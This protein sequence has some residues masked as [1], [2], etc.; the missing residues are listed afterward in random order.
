MRLR[1]RN[2]GARAALPAALLT[3]LALT[4]GGCGSGD[5][6][7][8]VTG[9]AASRSA[10]DDQGVKFAQCLREHGVDV[11]DP[12]PGQGLQIRITGNVPKSTVDA[13]MKACGKYD[14]RQSGG[15]SADPEVEAKMRKLS[16]CMRDNGVENFP[17]PEPG[18]GIQIDGS[19]ANDPDFAKADKKC[20]K[21]APSGGQKSDNTDGNG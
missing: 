10:Q 2:G 20:Q 8:T 9:A 4:V 14:P 19:V 13:A 21:Y 15:A 5:D 17:D 18:K 1:M 16:Q 12:E 11:E 6:A 3:T 7:T